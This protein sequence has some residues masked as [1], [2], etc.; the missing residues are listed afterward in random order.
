MP[1]S[2]DP[3]AKSLLISPPFPSGSD[4]PQMFGNN[5]KRNDAQARQEEA[6]LLGARDYKYGFSGAVRGEI[7]TDVS[8]GTRMQYQ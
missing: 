8:P 7:G 4:A 3:A 2:C 6:R 1:S 5:Q